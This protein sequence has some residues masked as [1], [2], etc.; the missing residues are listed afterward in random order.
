M[1]IWIRRTDAGEGAEV[2][3]WQMMDDD[4]VLGKSA[5]SFASENE[6]MESARDIIMEIRRVKDVTFKL[7]VRE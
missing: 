3:G 7:F 1:E 6:A 4:H 2:W 5:T